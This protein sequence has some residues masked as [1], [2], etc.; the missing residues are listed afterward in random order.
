MTE[1]KEVKI[2]QGCQQLL[3]DMVLE[4]QIA[5]LDGL[6]SIARKKKNAIY[7]ANYSRHRYQS[8]MDY[9]QNHNDYT[10]RHHVQRYAT[11]PGW[12]AKIREQQREYYRRRKQGGGA[13]CVSGMN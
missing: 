2:Q 3:D 6:L 10:N 11:D 1:A 9:R 5:I 12:R 4:R 7:R 13:V 8:D